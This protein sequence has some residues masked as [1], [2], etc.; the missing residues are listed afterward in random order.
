MTQETLSWFAGV[1]W[2][3]ERHHACL[4]D[5]QGNI[6]GE[7]EFPHSGAGLAELGD[8]LLST[9]GEASTVAVAIEVPHG[10][11][12][13]S[14]VDRGF[15]VHAINPKQLD[16]LR[17]RFSVAG[18]KDDR[19][20]AYVLGDGVRTDRRLFRRLHVADPRLI[21]LRA[22]SRLTEELKVE[23]RRLSNRVGQQ[24]WRYYPQMQKLTDDLA[25]PWFLELWTVAP[26]PAKARAL[27]KPTVER[28]LREHRIR[29]VN[30]DTVLATLREPAIKVADGVAEAASIHLRSL[31]ARLRVVNRELHEAE[32]Q[33][34]KLCTTIGETEA[35]SGDCL[36]R[37]DVL[38]LKSMPGIGRINLAALLCEASGP[39][40]SRDY[41]ALRTLSGAAP[42]TRRSGKSCIIVM[43]YAAHVRLRNTV[44]HWARVACQHDPKCRAKYAAL[45]QRGKSHGRA[46][47]GVADRL[48]ALACVLLQRG[49]L[50]DPHFAGGE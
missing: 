29:R 43:R 20:D 44:Y 34:D 8:W 50:F 7:R 14:L 32:G 41:Q 46:L 5:A 13:D 42:V 19:R 28:L 30:A 6:V 37:Q 38:I 22:W 16:R 4:V 18:A 27:R 35:A 48:L 49:T 10:P 2:G 17:D 45:R 21:E 3:S 11:V 1:D 39:L 25:E 47:R 36:R 9:A 24:L 26:T 31:I 33:L 23:Q 12:V 15:V 40:G